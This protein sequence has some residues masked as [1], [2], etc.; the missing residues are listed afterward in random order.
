LFFPGS[1]QTITSLAK[2]QKKPINTFLIFYQIILY[3]KEIVLISELLT[4]WN[5]NCSQ[6]RREVHVIRIRRSIAF[7]LPTDCRMVTIETSALSDR[8]GKRL[9]IF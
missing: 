1:Q 2:I 5:F 8:D 9:K 7:D 3:V 4:A 6:I